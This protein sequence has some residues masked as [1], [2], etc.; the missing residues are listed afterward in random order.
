M[1][2]RAGDKGVDVVWHEDLDPAGKP[3][4]ISTSLEPAATC[5]RVACGF[6]ASARDAQKRRFGE[7]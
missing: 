4:P 1:D 6:T 7:T 2:K 3:C 5:R